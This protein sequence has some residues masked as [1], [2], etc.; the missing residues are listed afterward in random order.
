MDKMRTIDMLKDTL[1]REL[2][3]IADKGSL[4][5]AEIEIIDKITHSLKSMC[6]IAENE[7]GGYSS[8][9]YARGSY[10]R[11]GGSYGHDNGNSMNRGTY[12][13]G[14][15]YRRGYSRADGKEDM[16]A[17]LEDMMSDTSIPAEHRET[18]RGAMEYMR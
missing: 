5:M 1:W 18:L 16:I 2:D 9:S 8:R 17:R 14:G 11:D 7:D 15:S 4:G 12:A 3:E 6:V 10:A 13:R